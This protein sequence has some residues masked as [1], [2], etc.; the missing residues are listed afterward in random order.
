MSTRNLAKSL[1]T[2]SA[3]SNLA[4]WLMMQHGDTAQDAV[5]KAADILGYPIG[6][7]DQYGLKAAAIKNLRT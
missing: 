6:H 5:A 1:H 2:V 3:L 4:H 7:V